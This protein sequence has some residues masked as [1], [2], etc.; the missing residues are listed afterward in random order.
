[1]SERYRDRILDPRTY[2]LAD[3][4]GWTTEVFIDENVGSETVEIPIPVK[5]VFPTKEAARNAAISAGQKEVDKRIKSQE[6]RSVIEKETL[7]PSTHRHG[8]GHQADDVA[9]GRD[10]RPTKVPGPENPEDRFN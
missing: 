2:E 6:I 3:G 5:G 8:F 1:M 7:L 4:S 10:G 9:A